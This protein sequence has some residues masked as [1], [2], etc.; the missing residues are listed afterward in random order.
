[1]G[2]MSIGNHTKLAV[3]LPPCPRTPLAQNAMRPETRRRPLVSTERFRRSS[4]AL[5]RAVGNGSQHL[6]GKSPAVSFHRSL[7]PEHPRSQGVA[8]QES[9]TVRKDNLPF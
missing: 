4:L 6:V 1:M 8:T 5:G 2:K 7:I 9:N 3:S